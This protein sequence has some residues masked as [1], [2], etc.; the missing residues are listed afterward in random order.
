[1]LQ[2]IKKQPMKKWGKKKER[3]IIN[4]MQIKNTR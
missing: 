2:Q 3:K 4:S 1:M